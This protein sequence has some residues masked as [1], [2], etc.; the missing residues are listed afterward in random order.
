MNP[1]SGRFLS[2]KWVFIVFAMIAFVLAPFVPLVL[3]EEQTDTPETGVP[4]KTAEGAEHPAPNGFMAPTLEGPWRSRIALKAWVPLALKFSVDTESESG[5]VTEDT[6]WL[7]NRLDYEIPIDVEVRK[8]SLGAFA[9]LIAFKLTGSTEAGPAR[10][11]WDDHGFLLDVGLSYELGHWALG[12]EARAPALRAPTLTVEPFAGARL[13]YD[14][15][16]IK[17]DLGPLSGSTTVDLSN[18]V[19]LIGLRTFWDLTKHWNLR[20]EGDYG[21]F[22][23]DDN[24]ETYN[25][26]GLIGYRFRGWGVGWNIQAGYRWLRLF[27]LRKNNAD[28]KVD[29]NGPM[30]ALA[31]EF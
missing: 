30:V 29:A 14:P 28:L 3:A 22:G 4:A 8:G 1:N 6:G 31:I 2:Q 27:D 10:F 17:V 26:L 18:Y 13:L 23:V 9:H 21:G 20:I 16:D 15:V 12:K 11:D 25:L 7:L 5:S 19:P 24:H